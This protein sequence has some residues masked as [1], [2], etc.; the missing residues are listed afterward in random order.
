MFIEF[1][2]EILH[3][4]GE[5]LIVLVELVKAGL[6]LKEYYQLITREKGIHSYLDLDSYRELT[7]FKEIKKNHVQLMHTKRR[8]EKLH[9]LQMNQQF[10]DMKNAHNLKGIMAEHDQ[11]YNELVAGDLN[12]PLE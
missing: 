1:L 6:R 10:E 4:K 2:F 12:L 3:E 7:L 9:Y 8:V 5:P 11:V